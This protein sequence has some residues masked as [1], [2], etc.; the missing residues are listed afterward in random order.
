MVT[1]AQTYRYIYYVHIWNA[2]GSAHF[3]FSCVDGVHEIIKK[4][5]VMLNFVSYHSNLF[6]MHC[7]S[8]L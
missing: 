1:L 6:E 8:L 5:L 3:K 7:L 4:F 2:T